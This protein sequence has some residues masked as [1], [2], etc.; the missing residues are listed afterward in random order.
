[1]MNSLNRVTSMRITEM[2]KIAVLLLIILFSGLTISQELGVNDTPEPEPSQDFAE[3]G[4]G[5]CQPQL[6]G[7]CPQDCGNSSEQ[8]NTSS[9][10]NDNT[11]SNNS[12]LLGLV[13]AGFTGL[14]IILGGLFW[15]NRN[16]GGSEDEHKN[17]GRNRE[18]ER[19][20]RKRL[21]QGY[22][23]RQAETELI[24]QG[25]EKSEIQKASNHIDQDL[26]NRSRE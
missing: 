24:N 6:Q 18:L 10:I 2:K 12:D 14:I 17:S 15:Y 21:R 26:I 1:M 11:S 13:I 8:E 19:Q 22:S 4:D 5:V 9:S 16:S 23:Y 3:C 7:V 20:L 25:R